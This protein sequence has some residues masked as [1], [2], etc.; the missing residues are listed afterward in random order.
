MPRDGFFFAT[1]PNYIPLTN[2]PRQVVFGHGGLKGREALIVL[3]HNPPINVFRI[4][5]MS[6][7]HAFTPIC[8]ALHTKNAQ[9]L[10]DTLLLLL[11]TP[12][13]AA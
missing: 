2:C 7:W 9:A 8:L 3:E 11:R 5:Y 13:G 1:A 4:Y 6:C 12:L 10:P